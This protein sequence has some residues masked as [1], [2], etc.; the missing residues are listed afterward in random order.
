VL[1]RHALSSHFFGW[2][3]YSLS[4]TE[5]DF[6]GGTAWGVSQFDQPHNLVVVASYQF[7]LDVVV[8]LKLRYTSGPL[9]R[10]VTAVVHDLNGNYYFPIQNATYS[11]RLPDFFQLDLRVD[12]RFVFQDWMLSLYLDVQ[13]V[14]FHSNVE[15][16]T[17]SYDYS[18]QAFLKGL[19]ILPVLGVRAEW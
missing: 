12:K 3:A 2:V 15:G 19:P 11:R 7:P 13:S 8:G 17:S 9:N 6:Q 10:P 14:T 4:R 16:V 5:R 1:L 18:Q